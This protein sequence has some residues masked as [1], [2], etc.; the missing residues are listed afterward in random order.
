MTRGKHQ[1]L[2]QP[3]KVAKVNRL[4]FFGHIL[5][6]PADRLVQRVLRSSSEYGIATN[7][8]ILCK[9]SQKI[10]KVGQ[11]CVQG[12]HTS[13]KM[14]VIAS[15]DDISPPIKSKGG[16]GSIMR[17]PDLD[18]AA[19]EEAPKTYKMVYS[20]NKW[21]TVDKVPSDISFQIPSES[22]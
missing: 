17:D 22:M 11:S 20:R 14:R 3:S 6:R 1:R 15:G 8:L 7:G 12:R 10:E 18:S 13:A 9:L 16:I 2:A 21:R 19:R 5:R 4:R